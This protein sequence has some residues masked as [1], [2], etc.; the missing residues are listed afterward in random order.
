M[1]LLAWVLL[2]GGAAS[3]AR[4]DR[5]PLVRGG[6]IE[7]RGPWRVESR[8][9]VYVSSEGNLRSLPLGEA[10]LERQE[11]RAPAGSA[12]TARLV[13]EYPSA[14]PVEVTPPPEPPARSALRS[15]ARRSPGPG[16]VLA[17]AEPGEAPVL[18]CA[19]RAPAAPA[20]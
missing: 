14:E 20:R 4:A 13:R 6:W 10:A 5:F 11:P 16:C 7:T 18:A 8:R 15:A 19:P 1:R 3:A 2:A 17:N 9:V 12:A